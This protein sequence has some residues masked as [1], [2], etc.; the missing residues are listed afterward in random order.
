MCLNFKKT[1]SNYSAKKEEK[2]LINYII[3]F[4]VNF[5]IMLLD[6]NN[7][8]YV[9]K[10]LL[11]DLFKNLIFFED[12]EEHKI[13]FGNLYYV[14]FQTLSKPNAKFDLLEILFN[15][16]NIINYFDSIISNTDIS[17]AYRMNLLMNFDLLVKEISKNF[18]SNNIEEYIDLFPMLF[19]YLN[20][21]NDKIIVK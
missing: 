1:F 6:T 17:S 19:S 13:L 18:D 16:E 9:E 12:H 7:F 21:L 15:K 3:I 11:S 4:I 20:E 5:Y 2:D 8:N 14:I 10:F